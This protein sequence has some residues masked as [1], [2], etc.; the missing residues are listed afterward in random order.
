MSG[1]HPGPE[2]HVDSTSAVRDC[3]LGPYVEIGP[4]CRIA[5][6]EFGAYSYVAGDAEIIYA[7]IGRFV[8]IASHTRINP[9]NHPMQRATQHHFT[10]RASDY[11]L[12]DDD[13]AFFDWR[14]SHGVEIGHD[15][16]IGHGA[17]VMPGRRI[18]IGAVVGSGTI[19]TKDV[20][21]Y[22]ICVG[23]PGRILRFRFA[24]AV[25]QSLLRIAWWEWSH[26]ALGAA[27]TD[28]RTLPVEAFCRKHDPLFHG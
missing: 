2:A 25:R 21:D 8:S 24:E 27:L 14:R 20:P 15:A 16:W 3:V 17:V 28:F 23:N 26:E 6:T 7:R 18:G 1:K 19:V 11:G 5:E 9:G 4:R 12:G 13:A 10:Y 22:A